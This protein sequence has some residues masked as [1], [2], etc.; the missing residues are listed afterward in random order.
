MGRI[1]RIAHGAYRHSAT[2]DDGFDELRAIWKLTAPNRFT[3]ERM[4]HG[5]WDGVAVCGATASCILGVGDLYLA[6]YQLAVR[7]RF[8]SRRRDVIYMRLDIPRDD[9]TWE[10]GIPVTRPEMTV[11]TL[12]WA[13]EDPSLVAD[14]FVDAVR[15]Y[16]ASLFDIR[17]M[18]R[19]LGEERYAQLLVDA[20]ISGDG[21]RRLV[22]LDGLGHVAIAE[23]ISNG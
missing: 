11:A 12:V 10:R 13:R 9:V 22:E 7:K 3:H 23:G 1:E 5:E 6:P 8:N 2:A 19:L 20:R 14:A 15:R 18:E 17:R 21:L 16:G 4:R